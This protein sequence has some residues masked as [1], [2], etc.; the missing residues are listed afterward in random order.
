MQT[1]EIITYNNIALSEAEGVNWC[2]PD[3]APVKC[4]GRQAGADRSSLVWRALAWEPQLGN[5][6]AIALLCG[7]PCGHGRLEQGHTAY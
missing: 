3:Q 7:Q 4:I 5:F 6:G 1:S 2:W